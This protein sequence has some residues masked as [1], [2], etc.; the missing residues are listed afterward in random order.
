MT[1]DATTIRKNAQSKYIENNFVL[2]KLRP[3]SK[4]PI[5]RNW[6]QLPFRSKF[7][8]PGNYGVVL[9]HDHLI[10]DVDPRNF[11][12]KVDSFAELQKQVKLPKTFVVRT[13]AGGFHF[14]YKK[15][16]S[17]LIKKGLPVEFP[18]VEFKTKGTQIV[19]PGS[20]HPETKKMYLPYKG[21]KLS[22]ITDAPDSL[23]T[24]IAETYE[25][26]GA[27]RHIQ[28]KFT[29]DEASITRYVHFLEYSDGA[30][31][32]QGG[33]E[34]TFVVAAYGKD[35][36]LAPDTVYDMMVEN[37]N[38]KCNPPWK[39]RELKEKVKNAYDYGSN[40]IGSASFKNMFGE[41]TSTGD[42][43]PTIATNAKGIVVNNFVNACYF[44]KS[45]KVQYIAAGEKTTKPCRNP[46][47][48]I[49]RYN[50][51][52]N[53]LEFE[54]PAPWHNRKL[55][56][57]PL[58]GTIWKP[59][60]VTDAEVVNV[61]YYL[62]EMTGLKWN[63]RDI[64]DAVVKTAHDNK[65]NPVVCW[66]EELEWDGIERLDTWLV[67]YCGVD[68]TKYTRAVGTKTL[69]AA[70]ARAYRPGIKFDY[71][72]IL[73]GDQGVGKSTAVNILA[74]DWY[75][76]IMLK[77]DSKDTVQ[78]VNSGWIIE[79]SEMAGLRKIEI[80]TLKAFI[81]RPVDS[82]RPPFGRTPINYPRQSI[83]IGTIN[84]TSMGYLNDE[85]GNR[86]YWPVL[87]KKVDMS[88]LKR[89]RDQLFA[90]ALL[91]FKAGEKLYIADKSVIDQAVRIQETRSLVHPWR[92]IVKD[93]FEEHPD[94]QKTTVIDI[95]LDAIGG[96]G[97]QLTY[98]NKAILLQILKSLKWE[99]N[100]SGI[101]ENP[102]MIKEHDDLLET[103]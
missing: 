27:P 89:D 40:E 4:K 63:R 94:I 96:Q 95:Y 43:V 36:G 34:K 47:G 101:Y 5:E 65:F 103:L 21:T 60:E 7:R 80:E 16:A 29:E 38:N 92:R 78:L 68:N 18:G 66:L 69:C 28:T 82:I 59:I 14:Y 44:L 62:D 22:D 81:S 91:R 3:N 45:P 75:V 48:G 10:I 41:D 24:L 23:L 56:G 57:E 2:V 33:D 53:M 79:V 13:G 58:S 25:K 31:Q 85:T 19:A 51:L 15:P 70:V 84:P 52:T 1:M 67:K 17:L 49:I 87:C 8:C 46:L 74:G 35:I 100:K 32:G 39:L 102:K 93:Y 26:T 64:Q 54:K 77:A 6:T 30:V 90:E 88:G 73:E 37:W 71:M 99:R 50:T 97:S 9:Q 76:D 55:A 83:F 98:M 72:L 86:R 61:K 20:I 12:H 42:N 11:K